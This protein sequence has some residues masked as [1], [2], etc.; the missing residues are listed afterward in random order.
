MQQN[1]PQIG[2]EQLLP[3]FQQLLQLW[4]LSCWTIKKKKRNE[5]TWGAHSTCKN[6]LKATS[7][8]VHESHVMMQSKHRSD[9]VFYDSFSKIDRNS[10]TG[11]KINDTSHSWR[12]NRKE[13]WEQGSH[14]SIEIWEWVAIIISVYSPRSVQLRRKHSYI[15][16]N[17]TGIK[18]G[19]RVRKSA[20]AWKHCGT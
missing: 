20:F 6:N 16:T 14:S 15:M 4:H 3:S 10:S 5:K 11:Y 12:K 18:W 7:M 9:Y 19:S 2:M 1:Q 17:L 8:P 13:S